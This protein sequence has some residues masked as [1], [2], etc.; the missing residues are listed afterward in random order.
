MTTSAPALSPTPLNSLNNL[1]D[2]DDLLR[3]VLEDGDFA[4]LSTE[5]Y[6][7]M[8]MA[9]SPAERLRHKAERIERKDRLIRD[10]RRYL[11]TKGGEGG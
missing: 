7:T 4:F 9:Y 1:A 6:A 5:G 10:I 2:P 11:S 3:R 8:E